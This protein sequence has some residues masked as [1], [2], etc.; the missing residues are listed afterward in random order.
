M[1]S[2]LPFRLMD[3]MN[4]IFFLGSA[5]L[6]AIMIHYTIF[7][8]SQEIKTLEENKT[9]YFINLAHE[10]KTPLTLITNYLN[11]Y[12]RKKGTDPDLT[13]IKDNIGKLKKDMMNFL[14]YEKLEKGQEFYDHTLITDLSEVVDNS[15]NLFKELAAY[16]KISIKTDLQHDIAV[17]ADPAAVD[18]VVNNLLDNA[19]KYTGKGGSIYIKLH[20]KKH[21]IELTVKD[22]GIGISGEQLQHIFKAY[23]QISHKKRNIQGMG[24]GLNIVKKIV[25]DI[26]CRIEVESTPSKGSEF[27]VY[28]PAHKK[29]EGQSVPAAPEQS[30]YPVKS[31]YNE[32][33]AD[34]VYEPGRYTLLIIEDNPDML[35]YLKHAL[36][37]SYNVQCAEN[38][39]QALEKLSAIPV[40]HLVVSDIMMDTMDGYQFYE[41][42]KKDKT[43]KAVPVIF[44]T[45]KNTQIE[46]IKAL[47]KGAVDFIRKPFEIEELKAKISSV[48]NVTQ[49]QQESSKQKLIKQVMKTLN[50]ASEQ[51]DFSLLF[52]KRCREIEISPREKQIIFLLLKGNQYKEIADQLHISMNTVNS[53]IR[54]IYKKCSVNNKLEL[55]NL[56][57]T[58]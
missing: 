10:T 43:Y 39:K 58:T 18:R 53:H 28:F 29:G 9:S 15:A 17:A 41:E 52:E 42:F 24:M 51:D 22:S 33:T 14:D 12:I 54:K 16:K 55:L 35:L 1:L 8:L 2:F 30:E 32:I 56:F 31:L 4:N 36:G 49:A 46:K 3:L 40:P 50:G 57:K 47:Q 25:D 7:K 45:A 44:L 37:E 5:T 19:V 21:E 48:I 23:H 27:K 20:A 11:K 6:I 13:I 38:G 34:T 26:E